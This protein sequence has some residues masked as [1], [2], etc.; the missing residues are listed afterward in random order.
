MKYGLR[1][2]VDSQNWIDKRNGTMNLG[3]KFLR[4]TQPVMD[5]DACLEQYELSADSY[6]KIVNCLAGCKQQLISWNSPS[7]LRFLL[8]KCSSL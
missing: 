3:E 2:Y 8:A 1:W 6:Y 5:Y 4:V 7:N